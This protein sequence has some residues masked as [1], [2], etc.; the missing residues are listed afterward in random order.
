MS[1]RPLLFTADGG[2]KLEQRNYA[3]WTDSLPQMLRDQPVSYLRH[4]AVA[5]RVVPSELRVEAAYEVRG[6]LRRLEQL[7]DGS[8]GAVILL[9]LSVLEK[10]EEKLLLS[11]VYTCLI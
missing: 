9:E 11:K 7:V 3:Y 8:S 4:V 5:D 10:R 2:R 6:T 1:E